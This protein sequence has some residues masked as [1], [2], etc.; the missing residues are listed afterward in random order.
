MRKFQ[1]DFSFF[2][3]NI[4]YHMRVVVLMKKRLKNLI[5]ID[6][7]RFIPT[8]TEGTQKLKYLRFVILLKFMQ[9]FNEII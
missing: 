3:S 2:R 1:S 5:L 7:H 6:I 9:G 4:D 8:A